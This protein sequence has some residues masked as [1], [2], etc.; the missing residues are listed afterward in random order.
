METEILAS[1][2]LG[3]FEQ[4]RSQLVGRTV[5]LTDGKAGMVERLARRTSRTASFHKGARWK[6]ACFHRQTFAKLDPPRTE[7]KLTPTFAGATQ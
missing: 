6:V 2:I 7:F 5:V 3:A 1:T 4:A